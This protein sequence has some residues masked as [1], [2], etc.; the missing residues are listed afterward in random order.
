MMSTDDGKLKAQ[1]ISQ[2]MPSMPSQIGFE[3]SKLTDDAFG[4]NNYN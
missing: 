4:M 3:D 2:S 1:G